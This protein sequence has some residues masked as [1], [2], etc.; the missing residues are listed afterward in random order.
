MRRDF[1]TLVAALMLVASCG[2]DEEP[3]AGTA[4]EG[5]PSSPSMSTS[6]APSSTNTTMGTVADRVVCG[7]AF[8]AGLSTV[9]C[10]DLSFDVAVPEVCLE[11]SCG[12]IVDIP[13]MLASLT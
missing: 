12:L 6:V 4:G 2:G 7:Q 9:E 11:G 10:E 13:G 1:V 8:G 5:S 3:L